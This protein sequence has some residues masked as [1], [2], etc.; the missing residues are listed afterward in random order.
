MDIK[1]PEYL[2]QGPQHASPSCR[3]ESD[4]YVEGSYQYLLLCE[5]SCFPLFWRR[6]PHYCLLKRSPAT[7]TARCRRGFNIFSSSFPVVSSI[8]K[9]LNEEGDIS[10]LLPLSIGTRRGFFHRM[11]KTPA[12]RHTLY[13]LRSTGMPPGIRA[14]LL[15]R[16][17]TA[18]SNSLRLNTGVSPI[19]LRYPWD[20][21]SFFQLSNRVLMDPR[22]TSQLL[23]LLTFIACCSPFFAVLSSTDLEV[24]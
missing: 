6:P 8:H 18:T 4:V 17:L 7:S 19:L 3:I 21:W 14:D 24:A 20:T 10:L 9:G 1:S 15:L 5:L 12:V 13:I 16:E 22:F 11:L 2:F 23:T